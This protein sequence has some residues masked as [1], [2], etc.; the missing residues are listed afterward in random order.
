MRVASAMLWNAKSGLPHKGLGLR[1]QE[2]GNTMRVANG[3]TSSQEEC[4]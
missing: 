1:R 3:D 2:W 4:L